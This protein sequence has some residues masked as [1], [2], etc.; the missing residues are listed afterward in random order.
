MVPYHYC[1]KN[2]SKIHPTRHD[3]MDTPSPHRPTKAQILLG[4]FILWQLFF[5]VAANY[6]GALMIV[7]PE[8]NYELA[9][10]LPGSEPF[11]LRTPHQ[12]TILLLSSP[13]HRWEEATGQWQ[14]WSLFA[15]EVPHQ[16]VFTIVRLEWDKPPP[17]WSGPVTLPARFE[18]ED[19]NRFFRQPDGGFR[20]FNY[21]WRLIM[22]MWL[23]DESLLAANLSK[24]QIQKE[25][26]T[27]G[28]FMADRIRRQW[29]PIRAYFRMRLRKFQDQHPDV[30]LPDRMVLL[31]RTYRPPPPGERPWHWEGPFEYPV[32][33][34]RPEH[35]PGSGELP[36]QSYNLAKQEFET[37]SAEGADHE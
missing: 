29:K 17:G 2:S 22:T 20:L 4:L 34:W 33:R 5:L 6:A 30:P 31:A 32:A 15:P 18:P 3:N 11:G 27:M 35:E 36:V 21:E 10:A 12:P 1:N 7:P 23:W 14:G 37:L 25:R 26:E 28:E 24:E 13:L 9:D 16:S 19:P 8:I